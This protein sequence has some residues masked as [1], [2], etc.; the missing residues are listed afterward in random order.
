M[1]LGAAVALGCI[2]GAQAIVISG[3]QVGAVDQFLCAKNSEKS[4]QA[5]EEEF[6]KTCTGQTV[7]LATNIGINDGGLLTEGIYSA[8]NIT[9]NAP[10]YFLLKFGTGNTGNDMLVFQNLADLNY[11]VWTDTQLSAALV[12]SNH[13]NS[14][15]H[16]TF[17]GTSTTTTTVPEPATLSL[18][19]LGL[20]GLGAARRRR[21]TGGQ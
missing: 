17:G 12:P 2:S 11:L 9:P 16:Y 8:I 19:G 7:S 3:T 15:S 5:Y 4:G 13:V 1:V 6:V 18:L 10:G 14:I 21:S 20:L